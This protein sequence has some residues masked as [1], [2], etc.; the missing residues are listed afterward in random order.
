MIM[1]VTVAPEMMSSSCPEPPVLAS[2]TMSRLAVGVCQRFDFA[3]GNTDQNDGF[4][5]LDQFGPK[6]FA[7]WRDRDHHMD[8]L[9]RIACGA[10]KI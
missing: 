2:W 1:T 8:G 9:A 5:M 4:G 10:D 7:F 6:Q 3:V